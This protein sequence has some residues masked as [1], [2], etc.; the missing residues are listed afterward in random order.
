MPEIIAFCSPKGGC[1]AT[2]V[3]A[4]VWLALLR[5]GYRALAADLCGADGALDFALGCQNDSVYNIADVLDGAC[6][7]SDAAA[8]LKRGEEAGFLRADPEGTE[9]DFL[10][11]KSL[12]DDS[13]YEYVLLDVAP[14]NLPEVHTVCS[15][16]ILV[17]DCGEISVRMCER[18]F[19]LIGGNVFVII[20]KIIPS[21]TENKILLTADEVIDGIGAAPIGLIPWSPAA[22]AASNRGIEISS[23]DKSL[24]AAFDN[25]SLRICGERAAA[26]DFDTYY[27]CFKI[28]KRR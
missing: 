11:M 23:E 2:F 7:L 24:C 26:I 5:K 25:I 1:G 4:G 8:V 19:G 9:Q 20:N 18:I 22:V 21:F 15:K 3:C 12:L 27:D 28:K 13:G 6:S 10:H 14:E 17:T 16:T